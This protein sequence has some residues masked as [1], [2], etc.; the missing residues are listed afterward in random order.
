MYELYVFISM[1]FLYVAENW[2][3]ASENSALYAVYMSFLLTFY[4]SLSYWGSFP[5]GTTGSDLLIQI[6]KRFKGNADFNGTIFNVC[7]FSG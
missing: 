5:K 4:N 1:T 3:I 6:H 2:N 7:T